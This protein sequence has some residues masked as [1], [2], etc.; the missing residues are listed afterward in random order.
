MSPVEISVR[1]VTAQRELKV[2][3]RTLSTGNGTKVQGKWLI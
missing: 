3:M 2:M 1:T